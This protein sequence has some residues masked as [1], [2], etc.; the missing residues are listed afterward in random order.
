MTKNRQRP[1]ICGPIVA[2]GQ[3]ESIVLTPRHLRRGGIARRDIH[4]DDVGGFPSRLPA[5]GA[6][7]THGQLDVLLWQRSA[8]IP[9]AG[10]PWARRQAWSAAA[11]FGPGGVH[12]TVVPRCASC[13][14]QVRITSAVRPARG[15]PAYERRSPGT[16]VPA[17]GRHPRGR[18]RGGVGVED[19]DPR[20]LPSFTFRAA[21]PRTGRTPP[22]ERPART[23]ERAPTRRGV[24]SVRTPTNA[25]REAAR[26]SSRSKPAGTSTERSMTP[27]RQAAPDGA[28]VVLRFS[29]VRGCCWS[30]VG[31]ATTRPDVPRPGGPGRRASVCERNDS[32]VHARLTPR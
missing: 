31:H 14:V 23:K 19:D 28:D 3:L 17:C 32:F 4:G 15:R 12:R 6:G 2:I 1:A 20:R 7:V 27:L 18:L 5:D 30:R 21:R 9:F 22:A 10:V 13:S 8:R 24:A 16:S 11:V 25:S 26:G 29:S